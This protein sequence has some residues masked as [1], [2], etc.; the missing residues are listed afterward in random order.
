VHHFY[1][2]ALKVDNDDM[3]QYLKYS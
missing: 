3:Q 1:S 2:C